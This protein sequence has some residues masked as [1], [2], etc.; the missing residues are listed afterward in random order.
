MHLYSLD[1]VTKVRRTVGYHIPWR[2]AGDI[3]I[4]DAFVS[5]RN[6]T[7]QSINNIQDLIPKM[8]KSF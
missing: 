3:G 4:L 8:Q 2:S 5:G 7:Q 1:N 6:K